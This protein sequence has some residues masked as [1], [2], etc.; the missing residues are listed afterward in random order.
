MLISSLQSDPSAELE[1]QTSNLGE[2]GI[3][4]SSLALGQEKQ[5]LVAVGKV[6]LHLG[7]LLCDHQK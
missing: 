7:V 3:L 6:R 1:A 4:L 2:G 5:R